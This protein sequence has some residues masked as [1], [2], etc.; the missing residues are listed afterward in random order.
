MIDNPTIRFRGRTRAIVAVVA[1]WTG[2]TGGF[3]PGLQPAVQAAPGDE[4]MTFTQDIAPILQRACQNCHRPGGD[5]PMS[6][7][8]YA[9]VRPWARAIKLRTSLRD[10]PPWFIEKN[11]GIQKFKDDPSLSDDDIAKIAQ[12]VDSGAPHGDPAD[13]PPARQFAEGDEWAIGQPDLIVSS[14]VYTVKAVAKDWQGVGGSSP[15][16]LTEDRYIRAIEVRE[17]RTRDEAPDNAVQRTA[18][19][20]NLFVLHHAGFRAF[21]AAGQYDSENLSPETRAASGLH[22]VH[23]LGQ[24]ATLYPDEVGVLLQAGAS[25]HF[26][27]VHLHS[28]GR[29]VDVR[30]DVGFKFHPKGYKP[31][32]SQSGWVNMGGYHELDIPAGED[33]VRFDGFYVM[34]QSGMFLTFEPHMHMSGNRMCVEAIYP[35]AT[36]ETLNC[37]AYNHNWVKAYSYQGDVAPLI[38]KGTII[39]TI[40][41]YDNTAKN[42]RN[43]EP[44]NWKGYGA[45][46]IDDMFFF[47]S[48][49]IWL[50]EEEFSEEV[51]ARKV[52]DRRIAP[53]N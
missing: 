36:R 16:G 6:L 53:T 45:R 18:G 42:R 39:H 43:I 38:P 49:V 22:H 5:A 12:W 48:K 52:R 9:D 26:Y 34:P 32:Y 44:R 51:A 4:L 28:I 21:D 24:N 15:T 14:P 29:E 50:S 25:L 30:L 40:G 41:W 8:T 27:T 37:A 13:M 2:L 20:L 47:F 10:M 33:N 46:S 3:G 35:D 7:V 31:K 17:V 23:E 11:V 19:D 1:L